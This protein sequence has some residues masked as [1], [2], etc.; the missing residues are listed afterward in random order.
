MAS[1]SL[2]SPGVFTLR[3]KQCHLHDPTVMQY[4]PKWRGNNKPSAIQTDDLDADVDVE[5]HAEQGDDEDE[6]ECQDESSSPKKKKKDKAPSLTLNLSHG[7]IVV[8]DGHNVQTY[9]EHQAL[10]SGPFR[11]AA[12]ARNIDPNITKGIHSKK[13]LFVNGKSI[14]RGFEHEQAYADLLA[15]T[16]DPTPR[17]AAAR[18]NMNGRK[19]KGAPTVLQILSEP[20]TQSATFA[21]T[22]PSVLAPT[23][24][25]PPVPVHKNEETVKH[26]GPFGQ[27]TFMPASY[28]PT[29]SG[30]ASFISS[31]YEQSYGSTAPE[32]SFIRSTSSVPSCIGHPRDPSAYEPEIQPYVYAPQA[33]QMHYYHPSGLMPQDNTMISPINFGPPATAYQSQARWNTL[34]PVSEN[35]ETNHYSTFPMATQME[36]QQHSSYSHSYA[37]AAYDSQHHQE[38]YFHGS[39]VANHNAAANEYAVARIN[40]SRADNGSS[41]NESIKFDG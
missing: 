2:G 31:N 13:P 39:P 32:P 12:T 40:Q 9:W 34:P 36:S 20:M 41:V 38:A 16:P 21:P 29:P 24:I 18:S 23:V 17:K 37:P 7:D 8:M 11:I 6:P 28:R 19:R 4:I 5:D 10:V 35:F 33:G 30:P 22:V 14:P 3:V 27:S 1:L 25:Q 15:S 26:P